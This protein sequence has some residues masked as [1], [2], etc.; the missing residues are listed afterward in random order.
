[1]KT[2][3]EAALS[4][5]NDELRCAVDAEK[6]SGRIALEASVEVWT[7]RVAEKEDALAGAT[8][9]LEAMNTK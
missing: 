3:L 8:A 4:R 5:A 2:E 6:T 9:E 7:A 1:M